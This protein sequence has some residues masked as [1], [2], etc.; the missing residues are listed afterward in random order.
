MKTSSAVI[1]GACIIIGLVLLTTGCSTEPPRLA[2]LGP[3]PKY[4]E[5]N[6][7]FE[8]IDHENGD[9]DPPDWVSLYIDQGV[10]GI[11]NLPE[12]ADS[13]VFVSK[14]QGNN[15]EALY[16]WRSG[17]SIT[18]DFPRLVSARIQARFIKDAPE[19]PNG[20]FGR[21]FETVIRASSDASFSN[22]EQKDS[23]WVQKRL[24]AEDGVSPEEDVFESYILVSAER[25]TLK[26]QINTILR[27]ARP[28]IPPT[29]EQSAA[30]MRLRINFFDGF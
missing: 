1:S 7:P 17:F 14:Q 2:E 3:I 13:Y 5:N 30:G 11:E 16:L 12:Y 21:Y 8:L 6:P 29:R 9:E 18:R 27:M 26:Q 10:Q 20:A 28:E 24:Y 23:Y 15:L 19:N 22:V 4:I 25:D